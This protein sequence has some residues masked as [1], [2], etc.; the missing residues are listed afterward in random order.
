MGEF[1]TE[2]VDDL[3]MLHAKARQISDAERKRGRRR[4]SF[5]FRGQRSG[6]SLTTSL[7]R[8]CERIDG[9][10]RKARDRE[11]GCI[12]E[13]KRRLHH[14]SGHVPDDDHIFE[15]LSLMQHHGAPTRLSD[16]TYAIDVAAFFALEQTLEAEIKKESEKA[17][18]A[19]WMMNA[20]WCRE[21]TVAKFR[22]RRERQ[23]LARPIDYS[24]EPRLARLFMG[25]RAV[26]CVFPLS[27]F[28]LNERL[29]IQKGVF[30]CPGDVTQPLE[31]NIQALKGYD[32]NLVKFV[33][34]WEAAQ[35]A[36]EELYD[37]NITRA[38]LFPGL[39]GFSQ[40][41]KMILP[42]LERG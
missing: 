23:L 25:R 36:V 10:L 28:R 20:T 41:L 19:I 16:W 5:I 1:R 29:T 34:P 33:L 17:E 38:A 35:Q 40:A 13:F 27:P 24:D 32:Q 8:V 31:S 9:N 37:M 4:V 18:A 3:T 15:W 30:V 22:S 21:A 39:D 7:Q 12:R 2:Q 6:H 42:F 14:Y 11:L 26:A